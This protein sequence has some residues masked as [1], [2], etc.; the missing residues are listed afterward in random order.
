MRT[1]D[2]HLTKWNN[3][4]NFN[5]CFLINQWIFY[6]YL[7]SRLQGHWS[8]LSRGEGKVRLILSRGH[9]DKRPS[10]FTSMES[11][12]LWVTLSHRSGLCQ[13]TWKPHTE[14]SR[15]QFGNFCHKATQMSPP[16]INLCANQCRHAISLPL[17]TIPV[18]YYVQWQWRRLM[19][20]QF[21][22]DH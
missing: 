6:Q 10:I 2:K 15:N 22:I 13:S 18:S 8:Q 7:D 12:E 14:W 3:C 20:T 19:T 5:T 11:L 4:N 1:S 21:V 9:R 17:Q 16:Y